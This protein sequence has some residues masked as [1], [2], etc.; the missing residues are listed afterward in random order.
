MPPRLSVIMATYNEDLRFLKTSVDSILQQTFR[1]FELLVVTEP[2]EANLDF[3][4]E[5]SEKD[6]RVRI[7]RNTSRLGVAASRNQAILKSSAEY[8]A[9]MDGDDYCHPTRFETQIRFLENN[10]DVSVAGSNMYL[11]DGNNNIT[12]ERRYPESFEDIKR[13]FI[14]TMAIA[15]PTVML[16][17]S[18]IEEVG[19][20]ERTFSKAEDFEL[21]LRFLARNKKM[22]NIQENLVYYRAPANHNEKRGQIHWRNNFAARRMHGKFIWSFHQRFLSNIFYY[23]ASQLPDGLLDELFSLKIAKRLRNIRSLSPEGRGI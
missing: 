10:P 21:W 4:D 6:R 23:V 20:F 14:L 9:I 12:G 16:K 7:I 2:D 18:A 5:V 3:L 1:D 15:N 13:G 11:V 8:I 17:R 22:H 19:L